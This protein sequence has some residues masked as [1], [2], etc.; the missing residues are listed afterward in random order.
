VISSKKEQHFYS[1]SI[2][3]SNQFLSGIAIDKIKYHYEN[4]V[5]YLC[6]QLGYKES[7]NEK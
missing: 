2:H 6:L 4:G 3:S 5:K 1:E 7:I